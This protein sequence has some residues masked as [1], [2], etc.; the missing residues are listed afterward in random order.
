M[1][2]FIEQRRK[3]QMLCRCPIEAF[4]RTDRVGAALDNA[5][6]RTVYINVFGNSRD[7][8]P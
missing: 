1:E 4:A 6:E 7:P 2:A 5:A 8:F 3:G